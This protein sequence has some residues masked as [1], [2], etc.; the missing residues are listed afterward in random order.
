MIRLRATAAV[1]L[2]L[3]LSACSK[4]TPENYAKLESGMTREEVY[5][6]LG[7]PDE[8][9]GSGVG[10]LT[11]S[12]ELWEGKEHRVTVTFAGDR[13]VLK[14]IQAADTQ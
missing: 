6:V 2:L 12:S 14:N 8:V 7:K 1:A 3:L 4:V 11:M 10:N 5:A 9:S 13:I